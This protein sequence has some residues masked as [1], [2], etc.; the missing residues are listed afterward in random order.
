MTL[1]NFGA[2]GDNRT[3]NTGF[4]Q[5][6][7]DAAFSKGGGRVLVPEG[8]FLT[9]TIRLRTNV[10]LDLDKDAALLGNSYLSDYERN[11]RWYVIVLAEKQNNI[12][13]TGN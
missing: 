9:G 3:L 13:I 6:A 10:E 8:I 1:K 4:I 11:N 5:N 7:I 2:V 12:A